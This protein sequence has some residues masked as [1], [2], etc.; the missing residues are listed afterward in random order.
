MG[1]SVAFRNRV[2]NWVLRPTTS[3][4]RPTVLYAALYS[5]VS[6]PETGTEVTGA[7]Y[8]RTEVTEAFAAAAAG[9]AGNSTPILWGTGP[10]GGDWNVVGVAILDAASGGN[11]VTEIKTLPS[12]IL[13][14]SGDGP[15]GF[16][17]GTM[18]VSANP[19]S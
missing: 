3:V 4:T 16:E 19:C 6:G 2:L 17:V 10:S 5:A 18:T 8:A 9:Q 7:G 12:A 11:L 13:V 15:P 1:L 14:E